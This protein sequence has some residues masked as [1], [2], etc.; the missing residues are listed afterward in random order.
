MDKKSTIKQRLNGLKV[1]FII[2][3][4]S[5]LLNMGARLVRKGTLYQVGQPMKLP[6]GLGPSLNSKNTMVN[7]T[8]ACTVWIENIYFN[9]KLNRIT[10]AWSD[11][12]IK[13]VS[14]KFGK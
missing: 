6:A 2:W 13:G 1:Q 12:P 4:S 8:Q 11:K 14:E 5:Q 9:F 10:Y 7:R 3:Y